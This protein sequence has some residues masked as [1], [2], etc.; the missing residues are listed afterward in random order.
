M[1]RK[2]LHVIGFLLAA[3][4]LSMPT[5]AQTQEDTY[6][7]L[8]LNQQKAPMGNLPPELKGLEFDDFY[9]ANYFPQKVGEP[10]TPIFYVFYMDNQSN[11][12][13][14]TVESE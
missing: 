1:K 14:N 12:T 2:H 5:K 4:F 11:S 8:Q 9:G 10:Y 13:I 7:R 3:L 6:K